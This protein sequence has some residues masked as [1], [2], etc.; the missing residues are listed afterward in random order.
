MPKVRFFR[1]SLDEVFQ[2]GDTAIVVV[3]VESTVALRAADCEQ[4]LIVA[5]GRVI[6]M[7]LRKQT[8]CLVKVFRVARP[9]ASIPAR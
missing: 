9:H 6:V 8:D 2:Q 3:R 1:K 7:Q 5:D 4:V